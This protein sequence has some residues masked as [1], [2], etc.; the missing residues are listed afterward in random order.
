M[1]HPNVALARDFLAALVS[2]DFS[3]LPLAADVVMESPISPRLS[4]VDSVLEF[5][6]GLASVTKSARLVDSFGEGDKIAI[7]FELETA[8]GVIAGFECLEIIN[9]RIKRVRP[10]FDARPLLG[11]DPIAV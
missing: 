1:S 5:L 4:G 9:G 11:G 10:Y 8:G 6:E 3:S 2:K 7:E